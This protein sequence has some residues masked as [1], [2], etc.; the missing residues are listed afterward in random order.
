MKLKSNETEGKI[1]RRR[2]AARP[3]TVFYVTVADKASNAG[4]VNRTGA[5]LGPYDTLVEAQ[6]NVER[7]RK[8]ACEANRW[9]WFY[10]YGVMEFKVAAVA[11]ITPVFG[12]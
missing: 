2:P 5:L 6:A 7:G 12:K 11:K 8:M 3:E 1:I 10:S 9:A 4:H